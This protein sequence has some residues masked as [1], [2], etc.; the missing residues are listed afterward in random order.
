MNEFQLLITNIGK[1]NKLS[2]NFT[3]AILRNTENHSL[4]QKAMQMSR[5]VRVFPFL[6]AD[7]VPE[8]NEHMHLII[9][10]LRILE[11]VMAP[12]LKTSLL[13]YL[14]HLISDFFEVFKKLF[15]HVNF[16]N[17]F[18]H[19]SHYPDV[20]EWSGPIALYSCMRYEGNHAQMKQRAQVVHNFR[21]CPKTVIRINQSTQCAYWGVGDVKLHSVRSEGGYEIAVKDVMSR[22][23]LKNIG[24]VDND[25]VFLTNSVKVN[26]TYY[27]NGV[28]VCLDVTG[29]K[30]INLPISGVITEIIVLDANEV[31]FRCTICESLNHDPAVNAFSIA[32]DEESDVTC[33]VNQKNLG[34]FKPISI[35]K[36][37]N[38]D[39]LFVSLRYILL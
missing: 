1:K 10:L 4:P 34:H 30:D 26:G 35:W 23:G 22:Q 18:H 3:E 13:P 33:F 38:S 27:C 8:N 9:L 37:M 6:I 29:E 16:I 32:V 20:I 2:S 14:K 25:G 19:L 11:I 28:V 39:G 36:H 17:K 31:Y 7:K 12:K 5:L 15:P 21:N 24:F